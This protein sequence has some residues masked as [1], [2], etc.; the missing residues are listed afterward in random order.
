VI[1][2]EALQQRDPTGE[3]LRR[4]IRLRKWAAE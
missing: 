4:A 2:R 1:V 3:V